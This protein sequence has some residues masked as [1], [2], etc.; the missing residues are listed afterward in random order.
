ML[1][2]YELLVSDYLYDLIIVFLPNW[3]YLIE[4]E[5]NIVLSIL[6]VQP[7]MLFVD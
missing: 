4:F 5:F 1:N 6:F 3:V 2:Y 7:E